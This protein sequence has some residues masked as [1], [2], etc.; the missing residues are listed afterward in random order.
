MPTRIYVVTNSAT[1][2]ERLIRATF[3]ATAIRHAA[4]QQFTARAATQDDLERLITSGMRVEQAAEADPSQLAD[5][6]DAERHD[7]PELP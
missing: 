7:L 5:K 4:H 2:E 3:R 1:R 6:H